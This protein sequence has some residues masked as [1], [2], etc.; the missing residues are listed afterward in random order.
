MKSIRLLLVAIPCLTLLGAFG[1]IC[2]HF[3]TAWPW[4][5]I[6]HENG[7]WTLLETVLYFEHALGEAPLE[8][9]LGGAV[10]GAMLHCTKPSPRKNTSTIVMLTLLVAGLDALLL[11]GAWQAVGYKSAKQFLLQYHT[12]DEAPFEFGSHWRYHLLSEAS[13]M[14]LPAAVAPL[15]LSGRGSRRVLAASWV[16]FGMGCLIFGISGASFFDP[17]YL[18]HQARETLTHALVTIPLALSLCLAISETTEAPGRRGWS[19]APAGFALLVL[20]QVAGVLASGSQEHAQ[21][22][23]MTR[24]VGSHFFEHTLSYLVVPL[25]A[26]LFYVA[27]QPG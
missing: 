3:D 4:N 17:R 24:L 25:H 2:I 19:F 12:R 21:T 10:A 8:V 23:D 6:V 5:T 20:Y 18:G 27:G 11:A 26:L 16:A 9:L 13:L 7:K 22:R 1:A 15:V 14:L